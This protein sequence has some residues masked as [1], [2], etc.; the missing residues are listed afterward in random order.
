[1]RLSKTMLCFVGLTL[2]F[3]LGMNACSS[4]STDSDAG[5]TDAGSDGQGGDP[6]IFQGCAFDFAPPEK[7]V[8]TGD[9]GD[10]D[11]Y[12]V[13]VL[14]SLD[15]EGRHLLVFMR[16][17]PIGTQYMDVLY[18]AKD[19]FVCEESHVEALAEGQFY[20]EAFHHGWDAMEV[21]YQDFRY[22]FGWREYCVGW[23][24]CTSMFDMVDIRRID[25]G[26]LVAERQPA[27]C[28]RLTEKGNPRPLVQQIRVP[29]EGEE[30]VFQMGSTEGAADEQPIHEVS[31]R[32]FAMD[33]REASNEDF[34]LFLNDHG[35]LYEG[36]PCITTSAEGQKL[37]LEDDIW[38]VQAGY[39]NHPVVQTTWYGA[40]AYCRWRS[41]INLPYEAE[42]EAAA[43]AAGTRTYPWGDETPT[44]NHA[45]FD[46]CE[47][48]EPEQTASFELG[49]SREG[50]YDLSGNVAEWTEDWYQEDY[51]AT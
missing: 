34:A 1:M 4:S 6:T 9:M 33:T 18:E 31:L 15:Y 12:D 17:K 50:I 24:P 27:V 20:Y 22:E 32:A 14:C 28:V 48:T 5:I 45:L 23:R 10:F 37:Y 30:F 3:P 44:C 35:N 16:A 13:Q 51:Y 42:W 38:K 11:A 43:S 49:K 19:A 2:I 26:T 47:A 40:K 8:M 46:S 36:H 25:D 39:E 21:A 29:A 7:H 41:W